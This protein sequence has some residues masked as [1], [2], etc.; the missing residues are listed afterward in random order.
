VT[1]GRRR[2][3][4]GLLGLAATTPHHTMLSSIVLALAAAVPAG[5]VTLTV[6]GNVSSIV[7]SPT[8]GPFV[9]AVF[10]DPV[11][12]RVSIEVPFQ[13]WTSP[14]VTQYFGFDQAQSQLAIGAAS[15]ALFVT[16]L[17]LRDSAVGDRLRLEGSAATGSHLRCV[18]D[19]ASGALLAAP[20]VLALLGT[21][22]VTAN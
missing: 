16:R 11:T 21:T 22:A 2:A 9:G 8:T 15:V 12:L 20:N 6:A 1:S 17:D 3:T 10:G 4:C 19:D 18:I 13:A 5:D 7:Q 14:T